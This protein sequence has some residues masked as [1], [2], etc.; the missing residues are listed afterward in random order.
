MKSTKDYIQ[1]T[2]NE[3]K[4]PDSLY[5]F[6]NNVPYMVE[7]EETKSLSEHSP[8]MNLQVKKPTYP[9]FI[10]MASSAIAALALIV[11]SSLLLPNINHDEIKKDDR[12]EV[13]KAKNENSSYNQKLNTSSYE[14]NDSTRSSFSLHKSTEEKKTSTSSSTQEGKEQSFSLSF[15]DLNGI[16]KNLKRDMNFAINIPAPMQLQNNLNG[17]FRNHEE[18]SFPSPN[19]NRSLVAETK[20]FKPSKQIRWENGNNMITVEEVNIKPGH[21]DLVLSQKVDSGK[22]PISLLNT[23]IALFDLKGNMISQDYKLPTLTDN[24]KFIVSFPEINSLPD[25][26]TL[27]IVQ[28]E[29]STEN[30]GQSINQYQFSN[31]D[32]FPI[33][34]PRTES[35]K[36]TIQSVKE[37][38][39][40][41][42]V[43]FEIIGN[44]S[45]QHQFIFV[46]DENGVLAPLIQTKKTYTSDQK[47]TIEQEYKKENNFSSE[48]VLQLLVDQNNN[49]S[50]LIQTDVT[51]TNK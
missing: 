40:S 45:M 23:K 22:D 29:D 27:R 21:T 25:H 8:S 7:I 42:K 16:G 4:A 38:D 19:E 36:I 43:T 11:S 41:V 17:L 5:E 39:S 31:H 46:Q 6:A 15:S 28:T 2:L 18:T 44:P 3:I 24:G 9:N 30:I 26:F 13:N 50:Y 37:T 32:S 47:L 34:V 35:Q 33:D 14:L 49:I 48:I 12:K 10:K 51:L 1:N 20:S